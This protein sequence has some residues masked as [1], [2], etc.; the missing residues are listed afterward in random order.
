MPEMTILGVSTKVITM[1]EKKWA[2]KIVT[3]LRKNGWHVQRNSWVGVGNQYMKG[4][5]D[6]VCVRRNVLFVELKTFFGQLK[7]AQ[8]EWRDWILAAGGQWEL[9][10]PQH[11]DEIKQKLEGGHF[12]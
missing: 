9:W 10:R 7:P 5:P 12:G 4:F 3:Y 8:E 11:W 2:T 6:L 1:P